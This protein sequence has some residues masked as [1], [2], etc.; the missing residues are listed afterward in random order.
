MLRKLLILVI[1][2][3]NIDLIS[4]CKSTPKLPVVPVKNYADC[5][6]NLLDCKVTGTIKGGTPAKENAFPW[7]IYIYS[8]DR[9]LDLG[10]NVNDLDLPELCKNETKSRKKNE[11]ARRICGG[12]LITP[13]Y[14]MT[15][16][17]CVACRTIEDTAVVLGENIVEVNIF[18]TNF[19]YLASIDIFPKYK[20]GV[21]EDLTNNPD[22]ALLQLEF[23]VKFGPSINAICLPPSPYRLYEDESM[24]IAG[25]GVSDNNKVSNKLMETNVKVY[26]NNKCKAWDTGYNFLKR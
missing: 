9:E 11:P 18:T 25:W 13:R 20:R 19:V 16:A 2:I 3:F 15:A 6:I 5:G 10:I 22:V 21:N 7:I 1:L 26:P 14:V 8:Y 12:S 23:A 24:V 4:G 17:H